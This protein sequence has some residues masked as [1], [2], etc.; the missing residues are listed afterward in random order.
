MLDLAFAICLLS[1]VTLPFRSEHSVIAVG[2][3]VLVILAWRANRDRVR[4]AD[5]ATGL[6]L[7]PLFPLIA[8]AQ[9]YLDRW[10]PYLGSS[11]ILFGNLGAI[12]T[13]V[14][15]NPFPTARLHRVIRS[16]R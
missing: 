2:V 10:V 7:I 11:V 16:R 4:E 8:I 15:G 9:H 12:A 6:S 13:L 3:W 5:A 14:R 1:S